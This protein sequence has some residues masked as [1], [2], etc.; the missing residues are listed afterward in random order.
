MLHDTR[1]ILPLLFPLLACTGEPRVAIVDVQQAFQRSPLGMVAALRVKESMGGTQRDLKKRG[2]RLAELKQQI[3]HGG[4]QMDAL[5]RQQIL[6]SIQQEAAQLADLQRNYRIQLAEAQQRLGQEMIERVE[7][8]AREIAE[9]EGLALLF[10]RQD[11]LYTGKQADEVSL[12]ITEQV[13][14]TLLDK[15]NPEQIPEPPE[16][17]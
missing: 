17:G 1:L 13:I 5:R 8:V 2:R 7:A 4:I 12:D 16:A 9:R 14:R 15:I 3:E 10:R 11:A 6:L